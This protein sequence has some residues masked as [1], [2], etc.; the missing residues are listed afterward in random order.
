MKKRGQVSI[1]IVIGIV[2]VALIGVFYYIG[3]SQVERPE[4]VSFNVGPV[5]EF[6]EDCV[7]SEVLDV[8]KKVYD[9]SGYLEGGVVNICRPGDYYRSKKDIEDDMNDYLEENIDCDLSSFDLGNLVV[10]DVG[11]VIKDKEI[12]V[13]LDVEDIVVSRGDNEVRINRF[14]VEVPLRFGETYDWVHKI[15][16]GVLRGNLDENW[17]NFWNEARENKFH[18]SRPGINDNIRYGVQDIN[19]KDWIFKFNC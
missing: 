5:E 17:E 4:V 8:F 12:L 14:N 15:K 3:S 13:D 2:I 11:V 16:E 6:V 7:E 10:R 1:F 19:A 9:N 18:L